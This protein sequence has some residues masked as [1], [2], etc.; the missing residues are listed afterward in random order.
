[1][2]QEDLEQC[3]QQV[4]DLQEKLRIAQARV[5]KLENGLRAWKIDAAAMSLHAG[6][7]NVLRVRYAD[8][9]GHIIGILGGES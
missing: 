4:A 2:A 7:D 5:L 3:R 9:E 1:M 6:N 8:I